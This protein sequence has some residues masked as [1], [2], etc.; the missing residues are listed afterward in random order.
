MGSNGI[1]HSL[2]S[3]DRFCVVCISRK[4]PRVISSQSCIEKL[5]KSRNKE[6]GHFQQGV[7]EGGKSEQMA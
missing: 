3:S 4:G 5:S 6:Y 7:L 1:T 2:S